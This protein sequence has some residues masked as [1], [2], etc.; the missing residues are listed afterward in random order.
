MK[1]RIVRLVSAGV[2]IALAFALMVGCS[3]GPT[4]NPS[5]EKVTDMKVGVLPL[6]SAMPVFV[7]EKE[8]YF[9]A[10]GLNVELITFNSALEQDAA[11][12]AGGVGGA[13]TA[14]VKNH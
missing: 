9:D 5:G 2:C 14:P 8:G 7:A 12:Q 10:E 11:L 3:D 4:G 6:V 1:S 13:L